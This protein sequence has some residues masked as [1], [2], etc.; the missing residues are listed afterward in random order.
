MYVVQKPVN[1]AFRP[2]PLMRR[3]LKQARNKSTECSLKS[4]KVWSALSP[5]ACMHEGSSLQDSKAKSSFMPVA[6]TGS[7]PELPKKG[8]CSRIPEICDSGVLRKIA[9]NVWTS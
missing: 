2:G 9:W 5:V 6:D 7:P 4:C 8:A 3:E 1:T